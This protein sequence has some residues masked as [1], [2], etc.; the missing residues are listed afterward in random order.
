[1]CQNPTVL[2]QTF[3]L[4]SHW[5]SFDSCCGSEWLGATTDLVHYNNRLLVA[6]GILSYLVRQQLLHFVTAGN[7][8]LCIEAQIALET[9][10]YSE[11]GWRCI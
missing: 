11:Q 4:H 1:M 2:S 3:R 6:I 8:W 5:R 7:R 10:H 9:S